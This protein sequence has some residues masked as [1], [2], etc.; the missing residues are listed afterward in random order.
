MKVY[1]SGFVRS[2]GEWFGLPDPLYVLLYLALMII[3]I[4]SFIIFVML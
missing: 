3:I 2:L 4:I 1:I